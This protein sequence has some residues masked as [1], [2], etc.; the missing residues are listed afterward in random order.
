MKIEDVFKKLKPIAGED[1]DILWL[2][3]ILSDSRSQRDIEDALRIILARHLGHT[4][5]ESEVLLEPPPAE[6]A[7]G[8]YQL[9]VV[10]YGKER[11]HL[12]GLREEEWIQH[13]GIFGRSGC[14]KTNTA[15]LVALNFLAKGKPFLVFDWKR[16]YRDLLS[17]GF[18]N[19]IWVFTVGRDVSPFFFNPL[20]PP[21]G[22]PPEMWLKKLIEIMC[23]SYFLGEGVA[24]LLQKAIDSVYREFGVYGESPQAYPTMGDVK[25]WLERYRSKGRESAWMDSALR[26]VGVLCFGETGRVLNQRHAFPLEGLLSRNVI[27]ELDALTNSD[28][29]FLIESLLLWIHHY[30]MAQG[31][32]EEFKHA[33]IIEEAHHILL[34]KK[35]EVMGEEAVTDVILREIRELGE[36]IV[37]IDQHPSLISKPA[38][39]NTYCTVSMNLKHR[40]DIAMIADSLL[41]DSK[42]ARYLG[43]LE[44]G[45]A[46]VKL[47]GRWFEPFLVRFPLV[48]LEK[49]AVTDRDVKARMER[50]VAEQGVFR[51]AGDISGSDSGP[52]D[53]FR[54]FRGTG[55][56]RQGQTEKPAKSEELLLRDI[57][58]HRLSSTGERYAR[59]GLNAYQGN[60]ARQSL[61]RKGLIEVKDMPTRTGRL[62]LL[63]LT[64]RGKKAVEGLGVN[65]DSSCRHGGPEHEY[66][67]KKLAEEYRSKGWQVVEEYPLGKGKAVDLACFRDGRQLAVEI[68][69]GKSDAAYN[70]KKCMQAGFDEVR[71]VRV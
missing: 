67:K 21:E 60:K 1:L 49:G 52:P 13:V 41:L 8:E 16:N 71:S 66:W 5:E 39:G 34:R 22:T 11:F 36:A 12:F 57:V 6:L 44:T 40:S 56:G 29:T 9:G 35:Q 17:L 63:E 4:Y 65:P 26:A 19:E 32:R 7:W 10:F 42:Q 37:L 46:M 69:T 30:R 54:V 15:F 43:K 64:D 55:K 31:S 45:T 33:L 14:G 48:R 18:E 38:M 62:K 2:E 70:L 20:V 58:E 50:C 23:H 28:K 59:L 24:Y 68:E 47:Q 27:L 25:E 61:L 3:Y 53:V 51:P